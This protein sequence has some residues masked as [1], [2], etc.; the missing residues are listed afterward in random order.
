MRIDLVFSVVTD[1]DSPHAA[2]N[3]TIL[4]TTEREERATVARLYR[5]AGRWELDYLNGR[6]GGATG[7]AVG[8]ALLA[9]VTAMP[10]VYHGQPYAAPTADAAATD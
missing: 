4:R 6:A 3:C 8:A 2:D 1:A 9:N 7:L 5:N 10:V